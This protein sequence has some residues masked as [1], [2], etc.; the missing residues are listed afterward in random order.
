MDDTLV[1]L[2]LIRD[3]PVGQVILRLT[4]GGW[5]FEDTIEIESEMLTKVVMIPTAVGDLQIEGI[6]SDAKMGLVRRREEEPVLE[7]L[8]SPYV[9]FLQVGRYTL[10][11][12]HRDYEI[13][14]QEIEIKQGETLLVRPRLVHTEEY[15]R[16]EE[17]AA[18]REELKDL[19]VTRQG[20]LERR[21]T[22]SISAL[23]S[24]IVAALGGGGVGVS[25]Y[26]I[27]MRMPEVE[28]EYGRYAASTDPNEAAA[29]WAGV[30]TFRSG[31]EVLRVLRTVSL[32]VSVSSATLGVIFPGVKPSLPGIEERIRE[33]R[34]QLP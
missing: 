24:V 5:F 12:E 14:E 10:T 4:G 29:L 15:R 33:V 16:E 18:L 13:L 22:L 19:E 31:V 25:E 21:R 8:P 23:V 20:V 34:E 32:S 28:Q 17:V 7:S 6:P 1:S 3:L 27:S 9:R 11:V 30:E 26:L 2:G